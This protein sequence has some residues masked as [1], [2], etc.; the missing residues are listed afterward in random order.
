MKTN[1]DLQL[2]YQQETDEESVKVNIFINDYDSKEPLTL[3]SVDSSIDGCEETNVFKDDYVQWL[4]NK[5]LILLNK[6]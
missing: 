5:L 3:N 1:K 4:E 6:Q 2:Q